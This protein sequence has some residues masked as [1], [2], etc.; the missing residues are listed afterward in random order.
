M[1]LL[2]GLEDVEGAEEVH[3]STLIA[4]VYVVIE[5]DSVKK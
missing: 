1:G 3:A 5:M 2:D 4:G